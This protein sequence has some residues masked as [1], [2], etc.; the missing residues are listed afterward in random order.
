MSESDDNNYYVPTLQGRRIHN[1]TPETE[2][3]RLLESLRM[4]HGLIFYEPPNN[5]FIKVFIEPLRRKRCERG[6][7]T[8]KYF[9]LYESAQ[10]LT[11]QKNGKPLKAMHREIPPRLVCFQA[12][13]ATSNSPTFGQSN[14]PRQD[15]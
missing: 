8:G 14:S 13:M 12:L 1:A 11:L 9:Q 6:I 10:K 4:Y 7:D 3:A 15:T 2:V 5:D